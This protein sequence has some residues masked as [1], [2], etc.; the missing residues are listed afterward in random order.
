VNG[1]H[2]PFCGFWVDVT[3]HI[4][5]GNTNEIRVF[6]DNR[7]KPNCRWYTGTGIYGHVWM[8]VGEALAVKP[9]ALHVT[10]KKL[11]GTEAVLS[12][13]AE[14][15]NETGGEQKARITCMVFD[16]KG[17]EIAR[18]T[19]SLMIP[20]KEKMSDKERT[21]RE[22]LETKDITPWDLEM[23]YLYT[24]RVEVTADNGFTNTAE[25]RTGIRVIS[26]D[27]EKGFSLNG[28]PVKLKGGC[29]HGD[30][31][32][33][34][35][36]GHD[37]AIRRKIRLLKE[38]GFNALR[39]AHNPYLPGYFEACDELGMLAIEEAFDEWVLARTSFGIYQCFE[40]E[41]EAVLE[42]MVG[43]DYNHPSIILWSTGNEVEERDGSADGYAWS[44]RLAE[45]VRAL[46]A[47]RPVSVTAC[48]LPEEYGKRP[49]N[50][51]TGNQALNMA[52]DN[53]ESGVDLWG[54]KTAAFFA[55]VDVAG[56]N[57]KSVRYAHDGR[58]FPQRVIYGSESY[59]RGAY[60]SWQATLENSHVI[61]DFVWTAMDY[62]GE[63]GLGRFAL[64]EGMFPPS[65]VWPWLTAHCGDLDLIGD[66]R[67]QSYYRD[68][69]WRRNNAPRLFVQPPELTGKQLLR[70]AWTWDPVERNYTY[71]G[72]EGQDIEAHIYAAADEVELLQNGKSLGRK[73]PEEYKA[74]FVTP[75]EPGELTAIAYQDNKETGRD[76][77]K[78]TGK[79]ASIA[80]TADRNAILAD[81]ADLCF[82]TL[83]ALD[84]NG[85]PV[86]LENGEATLT[87]QGGGELLAF[88]SADPKPGR[89]KPFREMTCPLYHG[90]ALAVIRSEEGTKG[91]MLSVTMNGVTASL[92]IGFMPAGTQPDDIITEIKIGGPLD[93]PLSELL[94]NEKA[95]AIL[96]QHLPELMGNP[97]LNQIKS[98]SIRKLASMEN[99][100]ML[101][102][103]KVLIIEEELKSLEVYT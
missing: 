15:L 89:L 40:H 34:G 16:M 95:I 88:G 45:K 10:I 23:P 72:Y 66:K 4:K 74:V 81:G 7:H 70:M 31:G 77:L 3:R 35:V 103:D 36:A 13:E 99:A 12:V 67:P 80:L 101:P 8:H 53:F 19:Q 55:P 57:Y 28:K 18:K 79:T 87:L 64:G 63:Q 75:Y 98:M 58:K 76:I 84:E 97:M 9:N 24:V 51:A 102:P 17:K 49:A 38:S 69:L 59:P 39:F 46:D 85:I 93:T 71:P 27:A 61:G 25:C 6:T 32:I 20:E 52:Y 14:L 100:D 94:D 60:N 56:Y 90:T 37:A 30:L 11:N 68:A 92:R 82:V 43:R 48:S 26:V 83:R 22:E 21:F 54:D 86:F 47:S 29:I 44:V 73:K 78:T 41:W 5:P 65:P 50:G 91:C 1:Y 62:L 96:K 2:N 33:L 42:S